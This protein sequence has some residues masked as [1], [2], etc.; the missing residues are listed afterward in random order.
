MSARHPDSS[1]DVAAARHELSALAAR[2]ARPGRH[3]WEPVPPELDAAIAADV[4]LAGAARRARVGMVHDVIQRVGSLLSERLL[5]R[6]TDALLRAPR[7]RFVLPEDIAVSA[8]DTPLPLDREGLATVS[9][10][11]AYLLTYD[12]LELGE[13]DHLIE[14]GT[15]TGYGAAVARELIGPDGRIVSLE[16]DPQLAARARRLIG[17][18]DDDDAEPG[19]ITLFE[20]DAHLIAPPLLRS[21]PEPRS[22]IKV[23]VT[24]A[25]PAVPEELI[26]VLPEGGRLVAP[27]T[28]P[29][30]RSLNLGEQQLLRWE[31]RAG[32]VRTSAHGAVR[33]VT[34]RH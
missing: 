16:I 11:H 21:I 24:Y 8:D 26:A 13:G 29:L 19:R 2:Y 7:E 9:A 18:L 14:L 12:L 25:L 32:E 17:L 27:V 34:A 30:D 28:S 23:A 1:A 3:R 31:K 20:G 33:Y 5:P 15:G 4:A 6:Y 10:P 22:P